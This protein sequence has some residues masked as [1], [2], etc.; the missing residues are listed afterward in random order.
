M[1]HKVQGRVLPLE[2][3]LNMTPLVL[4]QCG[5]QNWSGEDAIGIVIVDVRR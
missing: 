1:F 2:E 5:D 3:S 4:E